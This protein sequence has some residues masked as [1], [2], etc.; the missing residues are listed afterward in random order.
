MEYRSLG[1][2]G[3][4]V[5]A[6]C[7]GTMTFGRKTNPTEAIR[8]V[9]RFIDV[10]GNFIDTANVYGRGVSEEVT[11]KALADGK[12]QRVVLATKVHGRMDDT[13]P[14]ASGNHR[15]NIMQACE[16]SLRRLGTDHID[17][18]QLHRPQSSVPIDETLRVLGDLIRTG[19]VRYI[20]TSTFAAWQLVEAQWTA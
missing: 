15:L 9:D 18:Y 19:K 2:T 10:G 6:L 12:R 8:M 20:G 11:G 13:N 14:N 1:R 3:V 17:L 4:Q 5:S 7:L 16:D